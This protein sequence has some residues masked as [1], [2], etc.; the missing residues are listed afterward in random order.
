MYSCTFLASC[1]H[2]L[3][4]QRVWHHAPCKILEWDFV[5]QAWNVTIHSAWNDVETETIFTSHYPPLVLYVLH[6]MLVQC[7][8]CM[9]WIGIT[10]SAQPPA[11]ANSEHCKMNWFNDNN[12]YINRF[13]W[14]GW[15]IHTLA[16]M[17]NFCL[18]GRTLNI[19]VG[20]Q[21]S[22]FHAG[23]LAYTK[24]IAR[25]IFQECCTMYI[26]S[27]LNLS[28]SKHWDTSLLFL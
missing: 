11:I 21:S 10:L 23:N 14:K 17:M 28:S 20:G 12:C 1:K 19:L 25:K 3:V 26:I 22:L 5:L 16:L 7:H 6:R 13:L 24:I 4:L 9:S 15:W 8:D 27:V 18:P 2:A